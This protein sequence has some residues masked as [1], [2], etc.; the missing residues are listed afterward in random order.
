MC[1]FNL[2]SSSTSFCCLPVSKMRRQ[3]FFICKYKAKHFFIPRVL[4]LLLY[5]KKN[6]HIILL[7]HWI[8]WECYRW[9]VTSQ[10]AHFSQ[11]SCDTLYHLQKVYLSKSHSTFLTTDVLKFILF[12]LAKTYFNGFDSMISVTNS[13][14]I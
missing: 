5:I 12:C 8:V 7:F 9:F 14:V 10:L 13:L 4:L 3:L 2:K 6:L 11:C 1:I